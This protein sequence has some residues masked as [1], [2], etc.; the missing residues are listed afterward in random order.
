MIVVF[1]F[2]A[3]LND[4]VPL[5]SMPLSVDVR[6]MEKSELFVDVFWVSSF[7]CLHDA[8]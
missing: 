2:N 3:S 7:F 6:G 1:D 8:D 5:S 4:V